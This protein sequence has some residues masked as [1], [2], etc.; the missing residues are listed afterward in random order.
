MVG[1]IDPYH[2]EYLKTK[3]GPMLHP[4]AGFTVTDFDR[5]K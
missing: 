1:T 3:P 4:V 2:D 5:V